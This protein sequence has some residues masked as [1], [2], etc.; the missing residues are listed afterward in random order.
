MSVYCT[1][2]LQRQETRDVSQVTVKSNAP[3]VVKSLLEGEGETSY[4]LFTLD[5]V[6]AAAAGT[7]NL[8]VLFHF[9]TWW[10]ERKRENST[11]CGR[12]S[13]QFFTTRVVVRVHQVNKESA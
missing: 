8:S 1:A 9:L 4:H 3:S 12:A 6:T 10:R 5:M 7:M 2:V 13:R 11:A